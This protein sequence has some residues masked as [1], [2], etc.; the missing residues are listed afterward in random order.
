MTLA[1]V[2]TLVRSSSSIGT[3]IRF[4]GAEP[5][6]EERRKTESDSQGSANATHSAGMFSQPTATTMYCVPSTM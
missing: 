1:P 4:R 6:D 2:S 5:S 3:W